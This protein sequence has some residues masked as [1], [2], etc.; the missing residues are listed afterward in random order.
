MAFGVL[1][2]IDCDGINLTEYPVLQRCAMYGEWSEF[3]ILA[4]GQNRTASVTSR[5]PYTAPDRSAPRTVI[6]TWPPRLRAADR[7]RLRRIE[8]IGATHGLGQQGGAHDRTGHKK[9]RRGS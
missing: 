9:N 8:P 7:I 4:A 5:A 1:N 2:L 3:A 6:V